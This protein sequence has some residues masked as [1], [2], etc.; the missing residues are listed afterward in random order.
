[1]DRLLEP[2][3]ESLSGD[4]PRPTG[5]QRGPPPRSSQRGL[6]PVVDPGRQGDRLRGGAGPSD[7]LGVR[8]PERGRGGERAR[9]PDHARRAGLRSRRLPGRADDRLR[10]QDG[11]P[12]RA[13]HDAPRRWRAPAADG[14][15]S[16]RRVERAALEPGREIHRRRPAASRRLAQRRARGPGQ[17]GGPTPHPRPGEGRG[18]DVDA[19][20]G[21][22]RLPLR[23][24]RDLEP[25]RAAPRRRL[26]GAGDERPRRGLRALGEP[27]RAQ[28]GLRRLLG[29]RVRRS[30]RAAGAS[31]LT[32]GGSPSSTRI[33]LHVP[34]L[35]PRPGRSSPIG[36]GPCSGPASGR[37][38]SSSATRRIVSA[39]PPEARTRSS[40]TSGGSRA[41]YGTETGHVDTTALLRLRPLPPD[42]AALRRRPGRSRRPKATIRTRNLNAQLS[43]PVRR[44]IRSVQTLAVTYRRERTETVGG[45]RGPSGRGRHRDLLGPEHRPLVPLVDLTDRRRAPPPRLAPG[46]GVARERS[47]ARQAHRRRAGLPPALRR[48]RRP[49]LPSPGRHHPGRARLRALVRGGGLP[50]QQ[51]LRPRPDQPG[52]AARLPGQR[53]HRP[54]LR[55]RQRRVPLS[56]SSRPRGA[57][58]RSPLFLRHLRGTVFFDAANAWSGDFRPAT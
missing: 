51:P 54:A 37:R 25:P 32:L 48:A 52:G 45:E 26:G 11:R 43:L 27:R 36:R 33:P 14:L 13:L 17:R 21:E 19:R 2:H 47:V 5:R 50:G 1:M 44:T 28:P 24:R 3:P 4:P 16:R 56:R 35:A 29:P 42:A 6:G 55:G 39:W 15:G 34:T 40:V 8:R 9:P 38:G 41:L 30:P 49:R 46:G 58:A 57:G 18:A 12:Q 7:V 10:P 31:R 23:P 53:L 22:R 20:W